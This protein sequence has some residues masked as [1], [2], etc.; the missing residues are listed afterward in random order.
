[1]SELRIDGRRSDELRPIK[2]TRNYT[3][4]AAGSVLIEW[5]LTRV[6]VTTS[7]DNGVPPFKK[8]SGEGWLTA[9]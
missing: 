2:I 6:I 9:E 5:G 1:M 8:D 4:Q 7:V 3:C